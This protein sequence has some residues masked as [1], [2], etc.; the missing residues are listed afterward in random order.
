MEPLTFLFIGRS[1]CG[2]GTQARL[3]QEYL[4]AH[5]PEKK[6]IFYLETGNRFRE[7]IAGGSYSGKL[8][9]DINK[10]GGLQPEFLAVWNWADLLVTTMEGGEHLI[11]DGTPRKLDEA[12]VLDSGFTFYK[13]SKPF[14]IFLDV[15]RQFSEKR[16]RERGRQDDKVEAFIQ[17]RLD[18]FETDVLPA[19]RYYWKN[20]GY[21]LLQI[22]GE[23]S[24]EKVHG[25]I[26]EQLRLADHF[27]K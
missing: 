19:I 1:G 11:M 21:T 17:N 14:V 4:Q 27:S 8:S 6:K 5:D 20:P 9:G 25:D 23:Q 18:W 10:T 24:I 26:I 7:F 15:S 16:L 22:Q 2:K 13:R 3:L 12:R